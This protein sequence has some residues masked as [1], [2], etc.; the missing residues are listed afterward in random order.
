M[1]DAIAMS[2]SQSPAFKCVGNFATWLMSCYSF[3]LDNTQIPLSGTGWPATKEDRAPTPWAVVVPTSPPEIPSSTLLWKVWG[4]LHLASLAQPLPCPSLPQLHKSP[5]TC[6]L[7]PSLS[8][9]SSASFPQ[10]SAIQMFWT[11]ILS[12]P[13]QHCCAGWDVDGSCSSM[14]LKGTC[15]GKGWFSTCVWESGW[16]DGECDICI[17]EAASVYRAELFRCSSLP[18]VVT[19]QP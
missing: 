8:T 7:Q 13:S 4:P 5:T 9:W 19:W 2:T 16:R 15:L 18:Q 14:Y 1:C 3:D 11:T 6:F 10:S 17:S 12:S